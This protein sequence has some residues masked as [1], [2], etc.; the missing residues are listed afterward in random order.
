MGV[1]EMGEPTDASVQIVANEDGSINIVLPQAG[2]GQMSMPGF[3]VANVAVSGEEGNYTIAETAIDQ[4]V[5][6]MQFKGS[7]AGSVKTNV[8]SLKYSVQPGA[9]PMAINFEFN[10][11]K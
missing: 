6:E 11:T 2:A 7:I 10:G 8:L 3:T 4:K 5:G 9:M 1:G